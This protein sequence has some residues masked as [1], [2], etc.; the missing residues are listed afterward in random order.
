[1]TGATQFR[2]LRIARKLTQEQVA[3]LSNMSV[4]AVKKF[5]RDSNPAMVKLES[6]ARAIG[7]R[8]EFVEGPD[9]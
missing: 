2:K 8:I 6:L 5:E 9:A 1:M 3:E 7:C 4:D